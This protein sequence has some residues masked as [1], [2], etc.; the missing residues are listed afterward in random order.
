MSLESFMKTTTMFS[1]FFLAIFLKKFYVFFTQMLS[2][3]MLW[4]G[5]VQQEQ[6]YH[7]T[8]IAIYLQKRAATL[9]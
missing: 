8:D 4:S 6:M 1:K 3:I 7:N 5:E 9:L 2:L